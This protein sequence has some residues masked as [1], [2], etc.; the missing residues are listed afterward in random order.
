[1][2]PARTFFSIF[3]PQSLPLTA[4]AALFQMTWIWNDLL[5]GMASSRTQN[6]RPIMVALATM[7]GYG[8]GRLPYIM[9]AVVVTAIPT[10]VLYVL[11]QTPC[12]KGMTLSVAE[13]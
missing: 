7:S 1:M 10:I 9:T 13:G 5:F 2:A 6:I 8:G 12:I 4:L 3:L 11:L